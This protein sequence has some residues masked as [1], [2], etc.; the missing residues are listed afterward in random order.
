M[1]DRGPS[2][3]RGPPRA[4][5]SDWNIPTRRHEGHGGGAGTDHFWQ[6][7]VDSLGGPRAAEARGR[8]IETGLT[9]MMPRGPQGPDVSLTL[10]HVLNSFVDYT[11]VSVAI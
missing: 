8:R 3:G 7:A 9:F 11:F 6:V 4:G 5:S 10:Y 1:P 2:Y